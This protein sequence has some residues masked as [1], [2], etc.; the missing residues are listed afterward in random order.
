[1]AAPCFIAWNGATNALTAPLAAVSVSSSTTKTLLQIVPASNQKIRI[2]E[3][4][5]TFTTAPTN[6]VQFEL[7]ETGSV[8]ATVT[9]LGSSSVV[10]YND[11]TGGTT[12]IQMSTSA[13]G[14]TATAE[15]TITST[16]LLDYQYENGL[17]F[18]KQFPLGREPEIGTGKVLRIRATTG[19]SSA[20]IS[21]YVVWEE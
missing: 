17:Y 20:S 14:Y 21:T 3:W 19:A 1:M 16:R 13:S 7:I 10:A 5:Y 2:I 12:G 11:A 4:G 6:N 15:G 9:A 18:K 8:A